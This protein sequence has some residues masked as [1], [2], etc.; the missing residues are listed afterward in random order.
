MSSAASRIPN[1]AGIALVDIL[2]NGVAVLIIV[3]VLSIASRFE[4]EKEYN[5]RIEEVSTVMTR[6]FST[7][8]VL[9]R[10]A[11]GP[12]AQLHDYENS[13]LDAIWHP[14]ILPVLEMHREYVRDPYSGKTWHRN[15]LLQEPN[16]LDDFLGAFDEF[17][18]TRLRGDFYDIGTF[19]LLMSILKD[20]EIVIRHWHFMGSTGIGESVSAA[21]CP[22]G[23][24]FADCAGSSAGQQDSTLSGLFDSLENNGNGNGDQ[25]QDGEWPP[26][27]LEQ[28]GQ[29]QAD[30][31]TNQALPADVALG[32]GGTG[33]LESGSFP[34][35]RMTRDALFGRGQG[36]SGTGESADGGISVRLADPNAQSAPMEGLNLAALQTSPDSF[37]IALMAFIKE[38]QGLYDSNQP[39]TQM[40]QRFI[41]RLQQYLVNPPE[42]S[43]AEQNA[44]EDLALS[45]S[46]SASRVANLDDPEP[47]LTLALPALSQPDAFMK[48]AVNRLLIEVE[49][50]SNNQSQLDSLP[51]EGRVR[52]ALQAYPDV[53]RGMQVSLDRNAVIMMSPEQSNP[54]LPSW[55]TVVYLA[56]QL[57]DFIVGFVYGTVDED[58]HLELI[59]ESNQGLIETNRIEP[60]WSNNPFSLQ[61]WM[62]LLYVGAGLALIALLL[63][64][65][66]GLRVNR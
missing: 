37:L 47:L 26:S 58:G 63:F 62:T 21:Y 56:P 49:V 36:A 16:S 11:A 38:A 52:F 10:L 19:Y 41:P 4:Q 29:G 43:E 46:L 60:A 64:W 12:P 15:E 54:D 32:P 57:D 42:L 6:E 23:S 31:N 53:W 22:P 34:D 40:L 25:Q 35:A 9:N 14:V 65:R 7:S 66:P 28:E 5:E 51:E 17:Q 50:Q 27:E 8:L 3:I 39:P 13:E 20:H 30:S 61:T 24:S 48:I 1:F 45:I 33:E 2:A 44:I 55:R 18:R 59:A